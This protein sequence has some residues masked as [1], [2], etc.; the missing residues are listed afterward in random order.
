MELYEDNHPEYAYDLSDR[1]FWAVAPA[2]GAYYRIIFH[3]PQNIE[4][5]YVDTG[6]KRKP[7]DVIRN[8]ILKVS[9]KDEA[10]KKP[11]TE[12]KVIGQLKNGDIDTQTLNITQ[13]Y[14]DNIDCVSIEVASSQK[15][16]VIIREIAIFVNEGV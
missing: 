9:V 16:W 5:I 2:A 13:R 10:E 1:Y 11:C 4:R 6:H 14:I 12:L 7:N 8:G 15:D 3:K